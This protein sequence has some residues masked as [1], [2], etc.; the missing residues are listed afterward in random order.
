MKHFDKHQD[1]SLSAEQCENYLNE[2]TFVQQG[3]DGLERWVSVGDV[4]LGNAQHVECGLVQLHE[5]SVVDLAKTKE[6]QDL[7][8]FRSDFVDTKK[9]QK[10]N[11]Q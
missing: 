7:L 11:H 9:I 8:D 5:C 3:T 6:A 2:S 10:E 1:S 4:R